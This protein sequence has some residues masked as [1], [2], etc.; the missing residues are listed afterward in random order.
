[1][2]ETSSPPLGSSRC[3]SSTVSPLLELVQMRRSRYFVVSSCGALHEAP[4][5]RLQRDRGWENMAH[6]DVDL[7]ITGT[8]ETA[9]S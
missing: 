3:R 7:G 5:I 8:T 4:V 9:G 1:M 6:W 2:D